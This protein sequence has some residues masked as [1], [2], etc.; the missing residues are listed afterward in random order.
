MN[1][2]FLDDNIFISEA[3][4]EKS[5]YSGKIDYEHLKYLVD[6]YKW[7]GQHNL[8]Q[9]IFEVLNCKTVKNNQI[10]IFGFLHPSI[11]LNEIENGLI[12]DIIIFD[13]EYGAESN[14]SS[15]NWLKDLLSLSDAFVFVYS[16]VRDAIPPYLNKNEFDEF[17]QRFQLFL[18]G[19]SRNS[20]FTSEEF[21]LQYIL[22]RVNK[23]FSLKIQGIKVDFYENG[24]L[25]GP[26][27][28][29]FLE[30][31]IGRTSLLESIKNEEFSFSDKN[32]ETLL[33]KKVEK[34][35][36]SEEKK[37]LITP[38]SNF[39]I[40]KFKPNKEVSYTYVLRTYGILK[41]TE[42]LEI[43]LVRV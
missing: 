29:L 1:I 11:C 37:L 26:T 6:N 20:I 10:N 9:L 16:L 21:I 22:S 40:E 15:S 35:L 42:L 13:W 2:F 19:D 18:K 41:L 7:K 30:K 5:I 28:I 33:E 8:Q 3:N 31:I 14:N 27:D 32:I 25:K 43:G 34:L 24:Y 39:F 38:D 12:P 23:N 17:A 4:V 36:F